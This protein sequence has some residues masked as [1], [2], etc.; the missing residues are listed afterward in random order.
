MGGD[1]EPVGEDLEPVGEDLEPVGGDLDPED[2]EPVGEDLEPVGG[3]L[4][5]V[6]EDLEPVGEDLEPVLEIFCGV[7]PFVTIGDLRETELVTRSLEE[8]ALFTSFPA[9]KELCKE[10]REPLDIS[11]VCLNTL[12][13]LTGDVG[14]LCDA[15]QA[16]DLG[17]G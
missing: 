4:G 10:L 14:T 3:D 5:P 7:K 8:D 2:L 6:G 11:L 13:V 1:L 16:P 9:L 17:A 12:F 15:T